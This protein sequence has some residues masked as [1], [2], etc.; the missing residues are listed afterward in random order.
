MNDH[1]PKTGPFGTQETT[2]TGKPV[3]T[4]PDGDYTLDNFGN[5]VSV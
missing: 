2:T 1:E 3:W 5:R 4:G